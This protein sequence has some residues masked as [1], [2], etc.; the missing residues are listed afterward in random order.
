[1]KSHCAVHCIDVIT[2][3]TLSAIAESDCA[4]HSLQQ[5]PSKTAL[6]GNVKASTKNLSPE[7][8]GGIVNLPKYS[9]SLENGRGFACC[10]N[11]RN[12]GVPP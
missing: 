4:V 3:S 2:L 9:G 7:T 6:T 8:E 10:N 12:S 1:M 5:Y 11:Q